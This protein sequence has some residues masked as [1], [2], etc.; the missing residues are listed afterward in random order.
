MGLLCWRLLKNFHQTLLSINLQIFVSSFKTDHSTVRIILLMLSFK[1]WHNVSISS[2]RNALGRVHLTTVHEC[3]FVV[4]IIV[5]SWVVVPLSSSN[6]LI[7]GQIIC[8][9]WLCL[10]QLVVGTLYL[11]WSV[12][13]TIELWFPG[14]IA[15][16]STTA[17]SLPLKQN[18]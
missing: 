5:L 15:W 11:V 4:N 14:K 16:V 9:F 13:L 7:W 8:A 3:T 12:C 17:P 18:K 2:V 6:L 1:W 10:E